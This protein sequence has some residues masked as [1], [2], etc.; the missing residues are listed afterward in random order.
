MQNAG[1][2]S[3]WS[4]WADQLIHVEV[5]MAGSF[6]TLNSV[7]LNWML[8]ETGETDKIGTFKKIRA[9]FHEWK[10]IQENVQQTKT[11]EAMS[12]TSQMRRGNG[13]R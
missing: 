2:W 1:A 11:Q 5:T 13:G 7:F 4:T 10:R 3:I 8:N 6:Y 12:R 9:I